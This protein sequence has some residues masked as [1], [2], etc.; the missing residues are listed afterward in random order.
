MKTAEAVSICKEWL[1]YLDEQKQRSTRMQELAK[2]A[3]QGQQAEAQ[4]L[5]R[6]M[7]LQPHAYDGAKL[8]PAVEHLLSLIESG[9]N[10]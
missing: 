9:F 4:R 8:K 1:A 2:M 6:Q 10:A 7:D 3:R 5:R